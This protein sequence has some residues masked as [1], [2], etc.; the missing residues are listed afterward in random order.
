MQRIERDAG[1]P[2]TRWSR[3]LLARVVTRQLNRV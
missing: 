2:T 1:V 3:A